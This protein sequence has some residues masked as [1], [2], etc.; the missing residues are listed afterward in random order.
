MIKL[1]YPNKNYATRYGNRVDFSS[2]LEK[3]MPNIG[4]YLK[5]E[6][7]RNLKVPK[8]TLRI[9]FL[10]KVIGYDG[11]GFPRQVKTAIFTYNVI[12]FKR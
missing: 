11:D 5:T 6:S 1:K 3:Y 7:L 9:I 10:K 4:R 2:D 8:N 12:T